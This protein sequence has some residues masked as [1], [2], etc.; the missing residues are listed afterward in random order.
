MPIPTPTDEAGG[1][2][3]HSGSLTE[4]D[5]GRARRTEDQGR[6]RKAGDQGGME[7]QGRTEVELWAQKTTE[8]MDGLEA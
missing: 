8:E 4:V 7:N 2:K 1:M 5:Q 3:I 6:V